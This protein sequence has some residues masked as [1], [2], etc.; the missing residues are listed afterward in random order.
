MR[1]ARLSMTDVAGPPT[2]RPPFVPRWL[3]TRDPTRGT[4][5]N[6][7]SRSEEH[8]ESLPTFAPGLPPADAVFISDPDALLALLDD[9][10]APQRTGRGTRAPRPSPDSPSVVRQPME[11]HEGVQSELSY[12]DDEGDDD[13]GDDDEGDNDEGGGLH[14]PARLTQREALELFWEYQRLADS[15]AEQI[16]QRIGRAIPRSDL[17]SIAREAL[18]RV[19][20]RF[21]PTRGV[22]F[23]F[24]ARR[25]VEGALLSALRV[26]RARIRY[27]RVLGREDRLHL[28]LSGRTRFVDREG[29]R[30]DDAQWLATWGAKSGV[31][32]TPCEA[33]DTDAVS[34][35]DAVLFAEQSSTLRAALD[36]LEPREKE[37]I[38]LLYFGGAT[39]DETVLLIGYSKSW[40][41]RVHGYALE[42]LRRRLLRAAHPPSTT[43]APVA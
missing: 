39:L 1:Y 37:L 34:P 10:T 43:A 36:D 2:H 18:W 20:R 4:S 11:N 35:E 26:R 32:A 25:R 13:E 12:G 8:T 9:E 3:T 27:R 7:S 5:E 41:S 21:D 33:V 22:P 15:L 38:E 40:L 23:F 30:E 31:Q 16:S 19:A 6:E 24:F 42:A 17:E 29:V 28:F 14:V